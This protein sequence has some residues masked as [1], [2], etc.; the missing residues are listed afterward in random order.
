MSNTAPMAGIRVVELSTMVTASF[1]A[2]MLADQGASVIKI[3]P[4]DSGDPMR[5]L[6][7]SKG[8]ISALFANCNRGKQSIAIDIRQPAG[9]DVVAELVVQADVLVCNF[10]PGVMARLGLSAELLRNANPKLIHASISGFGEEGEHAHTP[11]YDHIMQAWTGYAGVQATTRGPEFMRTLVCDK[12]SAYTVCQGITAALFRRE[13]T[14]EGAR[15]DVS[16]R[17]ASLFFLWPDGMMDHTLLDTDVVPGAT[18]A[19]TYNPIPVRDGF[20][21]I[22]TSGAR[23]W[24]GLLRALGLAGLLTD[25]RFATPAARA[26]HGAQI[27]ALL[28]GRLAELTM[29]EAVQRLTEEDVPVAPCRSIAAAVADAEHDPFG[30]M[31]TRQHRRMGALRV[32]GAPARFD[33]ER[34][35]NDM[36]CPALGE[37][38]ELVLASLGRSAAQILALRAA[39]VIAGG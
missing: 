4:P 24:P 14:G 31:A 9:R 11:A 29:A 18:I 33:G 15:I 30:P 28:F 39:G 38:T 1:A 35:L 3:E 13:R 19:S 27:S 22:A 23:H 7:T 36:P 2:L 26:E 10:R 8:G 12:I 34:L 32:L 37:H 5:Y 21:I 25:P 6:G 16:M 17:D 20:I